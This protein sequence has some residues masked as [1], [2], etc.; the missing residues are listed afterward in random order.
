MRFGIAFAN[1]G[2]LAEG[3]TAAGCMRAVEAAG[4]DSVWTVEHVLVPVGYE[5]TYPYARSGKMPGGETMA[6][7]D[8]LI[9]LAYVAAVTDKLLLGT[10]ILIL[11]QRNAAVVAKE[12]ASLDRLSG[13]R[14]RLGIGVGWL[15]EEFDALGVPFAGRGK[16]TDAYVAA[17]RALWT[18]EEITLDDGY[19][20]WDKAISLPTPTNGTVPIVIGGHSEA[21]A[22]RAG[23][24]GDGFFPGKGSPEKLDQLFSVM[25]HAAEDAGRDPDNIEITAGTSAIAGPDPLGAVAE[26]AALGVHRIV[27]P[28]LAW[29]PVAASE[30]Y[31]AFAETVIAK[32]G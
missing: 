29:D 6:I 22:R 30:A 11:P 8:P 19:Q 7:P 16:R 23:R 17:M 26:M 28:P 3:P 32:A 4:F 20:Q 18:G 1:S 21:A 15:E 10:G 27:I 14:L 5:S 2:P 13:G 31:G 24:L 9:W 12:V 25:R